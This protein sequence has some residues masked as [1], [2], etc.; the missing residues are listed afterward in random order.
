MYSGVQ[1]EKKNPSRKEE[2]VR[3]KMLPMAN[4]NMQNSSTQK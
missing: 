3:E 4:N 2:E 1:Q